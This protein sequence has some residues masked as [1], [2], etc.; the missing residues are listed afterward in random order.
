MRFQPGSPSAQRLAQHGVDEAEIAATR[1][2]VWNF[3]IGAAI[4][5]PVPFLGPVVFIKDGRLP[6]GA[7]GEL[8][9]AQDLRFPVHELCHARQV[10]D[11][12]TARY[13][14]RHLLARIRT[15]SVL[16]KSAAEEVPC[17]DAQQRVWDHFHPPAP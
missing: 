12:G 4:T 11:W 1:W 13:I 15:F 17:Y 2:Y 14:V 6:I 10:L 16:A 7:D 5:L 8:E 3:Q 9:D